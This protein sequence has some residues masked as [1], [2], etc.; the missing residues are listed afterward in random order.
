MPATI[1]TRAQAT[2]PVAEEPTALEDDGFELDFSEID[3][4]IANLRAALSD[5]GGT[6]EASS[7]KKD[8]A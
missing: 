1:E 8:A 4:S 3:H 7:S 2:L 5:L 6:E